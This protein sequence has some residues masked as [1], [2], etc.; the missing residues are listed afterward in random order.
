MKGAIIYKTK[1]GATK[2][3][4][5][6][7]G[8]ELNL[9]IVKCDDL[10]EGQLK[11]YDFLLIGTSV[12]IGKFLIAKWLKR[13]VKDLNKKKIF[14]FIVA[15]TSVEETETR[16]KI[17]IDNVPQEIKPYCEIYFLKGKAIHK[18]LF[19]MDKLLLK[20]AAIFEKDPIKK[21]VYFEDMNGV[22]KGNLLPIVSAVKNHIGKV[23]AI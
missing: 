15:G 19:F 13:H 5:D 9:P 3:Y 10:A 23:V 8:T 20:V 22:K 11:Q 17:V 1:Y 7:L 12:Y 21:R 14:L 16:S 6:W 2:Q 4:A 18:E